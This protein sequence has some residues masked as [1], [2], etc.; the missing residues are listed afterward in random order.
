MTRQQK[1]LRN[2]LTVHVLGDSELCFISLDLKSDL[3]VMC[4]SSFGTHT[5]THTQPVKSMITQIKSSRLKPIQQ[6]KHKVEML[7]QKKKK[8][9]PLLAQ[10]VKTND[11]AFAF[12]HLK[13]TTTLLFRNS[14]NINKCLP[15][16]QTSTR[17]GNKKHAVFGA[18]IVF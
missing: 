7:T 13:Q 4:L 6:K 3:Q 18:P 5:C 1:V 16:E 2:I 14:C 9:W 11:D 15:R 12:E 10:L 8:S 17:P